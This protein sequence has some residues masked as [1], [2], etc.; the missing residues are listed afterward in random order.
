MLQ[1]KHLQRGV[2]ISD[3][4]VAIGNGKCAMSFLS[5]NVMSCRPPYDEPELPADEPFCDDLNSVLVRNSC[6]RKLVIVFCLA[7]S[8][9][10]SQ[11]L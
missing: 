2:R 7:P 10:K 8:N 11:R 9:A 3:Y 4:R 6:D 5:D 1:G